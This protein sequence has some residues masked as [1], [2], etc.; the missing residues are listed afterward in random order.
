MKNKIH[1]KQ[2]MGID[3]P[4]EIR[5]GRTLADRTGDNKEQL[6]FQQLEIWF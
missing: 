5:D 4:D 2:K 3:S 6:D 1:F